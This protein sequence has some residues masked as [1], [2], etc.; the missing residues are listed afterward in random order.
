MKLPTEEVKKYF[1]NI[2][3]NNISDLNE[4]TYARTKLVCDRIGVTQRNPNRNTKPGW[5]IRL[6]G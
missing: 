5:K 6:E 4:L 3:A 2:P 1:S